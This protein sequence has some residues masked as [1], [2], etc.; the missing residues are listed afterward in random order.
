MD[1]SVSSIPNDNNGM[2]TFLTVTKSLSTIFISR[3]DKCHFCKIPDVVFS[4]Y[5]D[6]YEDNE[7]NICFKCIS[8][9]H[10]KFIVTEE[11]EANKYLSNSE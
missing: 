6:Y 9:L 11:D 8:G 10:D 5:H 4:F 1:F 2:N 3:T 7:I